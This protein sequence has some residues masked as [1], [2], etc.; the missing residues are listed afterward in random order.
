MPKYGDGLNIE[1]VRAVNA[2]LVQEPFCVDDVRIFANSQGW[3]PSENQLRTTLSNATS[4]KHSETYGKYYYRVSRG[5]YKVKPQYKG[6][7]CP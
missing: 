1:F 5:R 6:A 4:D 3:S 2:G 7:G